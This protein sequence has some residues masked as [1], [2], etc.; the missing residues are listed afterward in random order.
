MFLASTWEF[1]NTSSCCSSF[2]QVDCLYL[3][4][5]QC[6]VTLPGLFCPSLCEV[7]RQWR[8]Q[9]WVHCRWQQV[10]QCGSWAKPNIL[11]V[12]WDAK[13]LDCLPNTILNFLFLFC[14]DLR[15]GVFKVFR[16]ACPIVSLASKH[17]KGKPLSQ[18]ICF[19]LFNKFTLFFKILNLNKLLLALTLDY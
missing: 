19:A 3:P 16:R 14:H 11:Y 17:K 1:E 13:F 7:L 12:F 6:F 15:K 4:F 10:M 18:K 5:N 8:R 9:C 2:V